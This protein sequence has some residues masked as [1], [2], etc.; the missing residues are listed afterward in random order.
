MQQM[1]VLEIRVSDQAELAALRARLQ[2]HPGVD[3]RQCAGESGP[4]EQG[5]GDFLQVAAASGGAIVVAIKAIPE[6]I[7]SRRTDVSVSIKEGDREVVIT[8]ANADDALKL[9]DK[10]TDD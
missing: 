9:L 10:A 6:F 7:R 1:N 5:V 3:V 2:A 4:G 8:A